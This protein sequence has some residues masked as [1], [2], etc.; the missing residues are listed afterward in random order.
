MK[1]A[2]FLFILLI[3]SITTFSQSVT[4]KKPYLD[5]VVEELRTKDLWAER[6]KKQDKLIDSLKQEVKTTF[7][8]KLQ[9]D[10]YYNSCMVEA[11]QWKTVALNNEK[12]WRTDRAKKRK[13]GWI[14]G[15]A[16]AAA[17]AKGTYD[18]YTRLK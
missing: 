14:I 12:L 9:S 17:V 8:Q 2:I 4:V 10:K 1:Y 11:G 5:N 7:A 3:Q 6:I 15:G 13:R 18:L 16:I